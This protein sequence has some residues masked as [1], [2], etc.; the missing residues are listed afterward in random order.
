MKSIRE[1]PVPF[2]IVIA[3]GLV[4]LFS[5]VATSRARPNVTNHNSEQMQTVEQEHIAAIYFRVL[6]WLS[7]VTPRPAEAARMS[8]NANSAPHR[9]NARQ[10]TRTIKLCS[11][12]QTWPMKR[13]LIC[14]FN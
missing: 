2:L 7:D 5:L 3:A 11:F 14:N 6:S 1:L 10:H 4:S 13:L 8:T 9:Q 12:R